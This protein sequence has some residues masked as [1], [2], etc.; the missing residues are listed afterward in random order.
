MPVAWGFGAAPRQVKGG[1]T[2]VFG[3]AN[4]KRSG[5]FVYTNTWLA[6]PPHK[7]QTHEYK[8]K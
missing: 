5:K 4:L 2:G 6:L 7:Q 3:D 8:G 1:T